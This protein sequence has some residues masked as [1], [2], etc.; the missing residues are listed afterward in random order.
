[1]SCRT[2]I[3]VCLDLVNAMT[4]RSFGFQSMQPLRVQAE[5]PGSP[6][7]ESRRLTQTSQG[8]QATLDR[9]KPLPSI[10]MPSPSDLDTTSH[11]TP[12][13]LH[14]GLKLLRLPPP[15]DSPARQAWAPEAP[16][17]GPPH[18]DRRACAEDRA[19]SFWANEEEEEEVDE[20][21]VLFAPP[22]R[23]SQSSAMGSGRRRTRA[24]GPYSRTSQRAEMSP[25]PHPDLPA[26]GAPPVAGLRLLSCHSPTAPTPTA[27][28]QVAR[29]STHR[30]V[31]TLI[32]A[33]SQPPPPPP[34][35][36]LLYID[37][38]P[39]TVGVAVANMKYGVES[40]G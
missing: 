24:S 22:A 28:P 11:R 40:R 25:L 7:G 5:A 9:E 4:T 37:P 33:F 31:S 39:R 17:I 27:F 32:P 6:P 20:E 14:P 15:P 23:H 34:T 8:P 16:N 1:M 36:Q 13:L 19:A 29:P 12:S 38:E 3:L 21:E 30:P 26:R 18:P 2:R 35:I 10:P